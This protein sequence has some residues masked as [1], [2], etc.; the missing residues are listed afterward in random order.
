MKPVVKAP[1]PPHATI[2]RAVIDIGTNSVKLLVGDAGPGSILPIHEESEQTRLG[3][4]FYQTRTIQ[5][6]SI[7][8]T[9]AAIARFWQSAGALEAKSIRMIATSAARDALNAQELVSAIENSVPG[10]VEIISG[11]EEARWAYVGA[12]HGQNQTGV[13]FVVDVGGGSTEVIFGVDGKPLSHKSYALGTVRILEQ[14]Q[15]ADAPAPSAL[16]ACRALVQETIQNNVKRDFGNSGVSTGHQIN[17]LMATGGSAAVI[18]MIKNGSTEYDRT[19][20]D[21]RELSTGDVTRYVE[22]LWAMPMQQRQTFPGLPPNRAD[23][24]LPGLV[25]YE[26]LLK[27]LGIPKLKVTTRGVRFA[28]LGEPSQGTD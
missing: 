28:L 2:R 6:D 13:S 25:I 17:Q 8:K 5:P 26:M 24:I 16:D 12:M 9:V 20:I 7:R 3:A 1:S 14:L 22:I 18:G 27:N 15:I 23:V 11:E 21:N 10:R 4:G 19:L